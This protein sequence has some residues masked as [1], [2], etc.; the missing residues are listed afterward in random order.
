MKFFKLS[1]TQR[2]PLNCS[3][4]NT[5][6]MEYIAFDQVYGNSTEQE[7][8]APILSKLILLICAVYIVHRNNSLC[9]PI[10]KLNVLIY[11]IHQD[12]SPQKVASIKAT[13]VS[14]PCHCWPLFGYSQNTRDEQG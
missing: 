6:N 13:T 9:P 11:S 12:P 8:V 3:Q 5:Q 10:P 4:L 14:S 1:Y 7:Q 2:H